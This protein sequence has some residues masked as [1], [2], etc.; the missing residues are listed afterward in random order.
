VDALCRIADPC[1]LGLWGSTA[2][3]VAVRQ[4]QP[5][6]RQ[7]VRFQVVVAILVSRTA[8]EAGGGRGRQAYRHR[9]RAVS[10]KSGWRSCLSSPNSRYVRSG[11]DGL[12]PASRVRA[13]VRPLVRVITAEH[14]GATDSRDCLSSFGSA[15]YVLVRTCTYLRPRCVDS[16]KI[17][18]WPASAKRRRS[19]ARRLSDHNKIGGVRMRHACEREG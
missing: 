3:P 6:G 4:G 18:S 19:I 10:Q 2:L 14:F 15:E 17:L 11:V 13:C 7:K 1:D 8:R 9:V 5:L 16:E 12:K